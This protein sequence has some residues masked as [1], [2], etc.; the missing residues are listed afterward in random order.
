MTPVTPQGPPALGPKRLVLSRA[1]EADVD[2]IIDYI[3]G[4][5][6]NE[7]ASRFAERIDAELV[8]LAELGYSGV[9]REWVSPGL[10]LTTIG[11]YCIYFRISPD[12]TFIIRVL[13]GSRD[14]SQI[15]FDEADD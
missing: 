11:V 9:S 7:V 15:G 13:H 2:A 12:E 1:A 4:E 14:V 8:Q 5:A 6:G 10:R 3:S